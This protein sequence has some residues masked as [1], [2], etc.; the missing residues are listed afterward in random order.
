MWKIIFKALELHSRL[1]PVTKVTFN[2]F[3]SYNILKNFT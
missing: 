2:R 3:I 1:I